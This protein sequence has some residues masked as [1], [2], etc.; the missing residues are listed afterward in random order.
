MLADQLKSLDLCAGEP[1]QIERG[2]PDG[3]IRVTAGLLTDVNIDRFA[4]CTTAI[5]TCLLLT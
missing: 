3:L 2:L 4:L 1:K 5:H